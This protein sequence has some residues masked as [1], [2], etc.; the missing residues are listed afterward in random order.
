MARL[1][2][3][4]KLNPGGIG[5]QLD[6]LAEVSSKTDQFLRSLAND[7]SLTM[8]KGELIAVRFEN[9]SV[10]FD[11]EFIGIAEERQVNV[12][13]ST[14]DK[15]VNYGVFPHMDLGPVRPQT[16]A[17]YA[18]IADPI[19]ADEKIEIG[20]YENGTNTPRWNILS[21]QVSKQILEDLRPIEY[22]G[23]I[24]AIIHSL[25]LESGKPSF[26]ARELSSES[27][28]TCYY[29]EALY[30]DIVETLQSRYAVVHVIGTIWASRITKQIEEM[31]VDKITKAP[32]MTA[33]E[34]ERLWGSAPNLT[35]DLT[36]EEF[37]HQIRDDD[38]A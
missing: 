26:K 23:G 31:R 14:L 10:A 19:A 38:S 37:L 34:L 18:A 6:K 7:V 16:L 24:Q 27:L 35:G 4:I 28:I 13:N 15:V 25:V 9:G 12:Y 32:V 20:I 17:S 11:I 36:T 22:E 21:K 3:R 1:H 2:F 33:S 30:N 8:K 5:A 29:S